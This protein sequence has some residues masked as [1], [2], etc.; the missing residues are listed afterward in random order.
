MHL[1]ELMSSN[2]MVLS[3]IRSREFSWAWNNLNVAE[4]A[5]WVYFLST[6]LGVITLIEFFI[7]R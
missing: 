1:T 3:G 7:F 6:T 2:D 5:A 4:K